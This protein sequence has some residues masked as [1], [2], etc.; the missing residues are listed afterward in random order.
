MILVDKGLIMTSKT[1]YDPEYVERLEQSAEKLAS[2]I[3]RI[4]GSYPISEDFRKDYNESI[5]EYFDIQRD[6]D[7]S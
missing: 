2:T 3:Q 1:N 7:N 6:F 4:V 5:D